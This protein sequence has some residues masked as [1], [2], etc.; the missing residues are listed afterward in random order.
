MLN[1][2][3]NYNNLSDIEKGNII[4]EMIKMSYETIK[5]YLEKLNYYG[6]EDF[7]SDVSYLIIEIFTYHKFKFDFYKTKKRVIFT[8]SK[9]LFWKKLL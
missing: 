4:I 3:L 8:N 9:Q 5:K 7:I 6:Y 1:K 2:Y